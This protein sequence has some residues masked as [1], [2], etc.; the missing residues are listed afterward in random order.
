MNFLKENYFSK[1]WSR[2]V[3]VESIFDID[4]YYKEVALECLTSSTNHIRS[5]YNFTISKIFSK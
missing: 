2:W 3:D 5:Y 1:I 4:Q